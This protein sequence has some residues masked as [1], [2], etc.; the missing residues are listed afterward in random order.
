MLLP[1]TEQH[2]KVL[3]LPAC[4]FRHMY[5]WYA[6]IWSHG[7]SKDAT[8]QRARLVGRLAVWVIVVRKYAIPTSMLT[9]TQKLV[10]AASDGMVPH[11]DGVTAGL[12]VWG[13]APA[14]LHRRTPSSC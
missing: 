1:H 3:N 13:A 4:L 9:Q 2:V 8:Q 14:L 12:T 6:I 11:A 5:E 10:H 7:M